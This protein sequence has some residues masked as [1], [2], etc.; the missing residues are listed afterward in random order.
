MSAIA[1]LTGFPLCLGGNVFG[2]TATQ[3][4]SEAVLRGFVAGGGLLVDTADTYSS[5]AVGN[6]GGESETIIGDWL[7]K[8]G[9]S[10]AVAI[11]TKV[12]K[13]QGLTKL[14]AANIRLAAENSL[15]RLRRDHIDLYYLHDDDPTTELAETLGALDSLVSDGLVRFIGAS[16]FSAARFAEALAVQA[17][18]GFASFT[19]LQ[20]HYNLLHRDEY[21][22][23]LAEICQVNE[24]AVFPYY[25]L[26]EGYL[27]GKYR[28]ATPSSERA[29]DAVAYDN[30]RAR[31]ILAAMSEIALG[32]DVPVAAVAAVALAWLA[33]RPGSVVPIASARTPHQLADLLAVGRFELSDL[34]ADALSSAGATDELSPAGATANG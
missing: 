1:G 21:E 24:I 19:A 28:N 12:G 20:P 26:A 3:V 32:H 15:R 23:G 8:R 14:T 6:V 29:E 30:P 25:S 10:N 7:V 2:W 27:T 22:G 18:C 4:Q 31:A 17:E 16:N 9:D 34:E 13:L 11:A 33:A 5:W